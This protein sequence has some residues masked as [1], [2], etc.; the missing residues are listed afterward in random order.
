MPKG[1]WTLIGFIFFA[2]GILSMVLAVIGAK[3][4]FLTWIDAFGASAGLIIRLLLI[5]TGA[6]IMVVSLS[7][8][9]GEQEI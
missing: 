3:F 1:L 5:L 6:I 7:D 8:F 2:I 9:K 4:T